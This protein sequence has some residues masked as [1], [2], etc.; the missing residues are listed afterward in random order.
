MVLFSIEIYPHVGWL[1]FGGCAML[2]NV[3][4][5]TRMLFPIAIM[6][7]MVCLLLI[8]VSNA[9]YTRMMQD[10]LQSIR[11]IVETSAG[12]AKS[13]EAEVQAGHFDRAEALNRYRATVYGMRYGKGDYLVAWQADGTLIANGGNKALEGQ[14]RSDT[15]DS[16]GTPITGSVMAAVRNSETGVAE[17]FYP[18]PGDPQQV[19]HRKITAVQRFAP[20][21]MVIGTGAY[22]DDIEDEF[23]ALLIKGG[24]A[25]ALLL[26]VATAVSLLIGNQLAKALSTLSGNMAAIAGGKL[27]T[28]I[29]A[30][31][32]GDEIGD[33]A[34]SLDVLR[35]ASREVERL[36]AEQEAAKTYAEAERRESGR[37][38]AH[39]FEAEVKQV[40]ERVDA[41]AR[42]MA[43]AAHDMTAQME[44]AAGPASEVAGA[45][46]RAAGNVQA[47]AAATEELSASVAEISR[48]V[49]T[50]ADVARAAV[51]EAETTDAIVRGLAQAVER[52]GAVV[53]L[54]ND[55]AAQ[56]NLL[57]LNATIEAARAGE[58][59]KGFAVVANEVKH[60]AT[61]TGKATEEIAQQIGSVQSET[62]RAVGAIANVTNTIAR[63]DGI[64]A[65]IAQ[66][67]DQQA[68]AT[69]EI[70]RSISDASAGTQEV[71]HGIGGVSSAAGTAGTAAANML[72]TAR[73]LEDD[74]AGLG[75]ALENFLA[76]MIAA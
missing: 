60:L 5:R 33:M 40:S 28:A 27:D 68:S 20:W 50:S 16:H 75:R 21:N 18:K 9:M 13:L 24:I 1:A 39:Q 34:R 74:A 30:T 25:A 11:A 26:L 42:A 22:V 32:R 54:I 7:A 59:G 62:A 65:D 37:Q 57:A 66:A 53:N 10:R 56:T 36:R 71:S 41:A 29:T 76:R 55:I 49:S 35:S 14:N 61:Q 8:G 52:I 67:V 19:P 43:T 23:D 12:I 4:V 2:N 72:E 63:M 51:E 45:S 38:I 17:Y 46:D 64:T 70:T 48:Q 3:K 44:R 58:A 15:K 47:V 31:G 73:R 69:H 6:I